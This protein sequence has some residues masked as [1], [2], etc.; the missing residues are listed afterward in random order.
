ML[1]VVC[2]YHRTVGIQFPEPAKASAGRGEPTEPACSV[3]EGKLKV[4]FHFQKGQICS[5]IENQ[6]W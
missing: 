1:A 2:I 5:E 6:V 3:P 4:D